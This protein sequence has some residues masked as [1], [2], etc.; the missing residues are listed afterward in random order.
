M[1]HHHVTWA[2]SHDWFVKARRTLHGTYIVSV[3][4][5]QRRADGEWEWGCQEFCS[6]RELRNWAGY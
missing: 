5:E 4:C 3:R 2:Q 6:Y 1:N